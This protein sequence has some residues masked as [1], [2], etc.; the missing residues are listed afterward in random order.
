M[1]AITL[2]EASIKLFGVLALWIFET[3]LVCNI[4]K[5]AKPIINIYREIDNGQ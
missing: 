4:Q 2:L 1:H 3:P 5:F